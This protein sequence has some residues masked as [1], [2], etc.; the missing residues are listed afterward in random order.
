[1][2]KH[3]WILYEVWDA[4]KNPD[5]YVLTARKNHPIA[6]VT[7]IILWSIVGV[8]QSILWILTII[9]SKINKWVL[10]WRYV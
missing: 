2:N 3:D 8:L 1:M 6:W 4:I 9:P 7:G 5:N 10:D